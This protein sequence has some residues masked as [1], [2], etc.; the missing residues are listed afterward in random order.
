MG[1]ASSE[2]WGL[3]EPGGGQL[4]VL[5]TEAAPG[6]AVHGA[7]WKDLMDFPVEKWEPHVSSSAGVGWD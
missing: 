4:F 6:P 5:S 2:P 7:A 1:D 3:E